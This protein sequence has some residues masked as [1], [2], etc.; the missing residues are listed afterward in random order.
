[1]PSK[2]LSIENGTVEDSNFT[3]E[4]VDLNDV[5]DKN[6][7]EGMENVQTKPKNF[8]SEGKRET[9]PAATEKVKGGKLTKVQVEKWTLNTL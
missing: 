5:N 7:R 1:M 3:L 2:S 8:L 9:A 4:V 6:F